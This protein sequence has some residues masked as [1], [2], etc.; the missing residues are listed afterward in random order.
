MI[1]TSGIKNT[2]PK[3][4][5]ETVTVKAD[6]YQPSSWYEPGKGPRYQ[7]LVRHLGAAIRQG[8]LAPDTQLPP[9]RALTE[10]AEVSR[11]TIRRAI[12]ALADEG[13]VEQRHGSGTFV[14]HASPRLE[15]SLSSLISFSENLRLRG[16][17]PSSVVLDRG[18]YMPTRDEFMIL[19]LSPSARVARIKRLR[20]ADGTPLA[21]ESS[22]LPADI[23][24]DP[25]QV[26]TSLYDL[27]RAGGRAPVRA[28]QR[29][30]ACNLD[31]EDADRLGMAAGEAVLNIQRTAYLPHGRAIELTTGL[32][33]SDLYDFV[34][35]L[36]LE[37]PT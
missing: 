33:R 22:T 6:L 35:E 2:I 34:S 1:P 18:L 9:E 14:C 19:G 30:T 11:V 36:T 12:R 28:I 23:L 20:S 13:L 5:P 37:A 4:W 16:Q 24:P 26:K 25:T 29:V 7:Q 8:V 32:Y 3:Y 31:A 10:L 17:T 15:Q 21:I 27:L